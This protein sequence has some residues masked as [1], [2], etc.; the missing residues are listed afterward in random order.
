MDEL[1]TLSKH[2]QPSGQPRSL[3][4]LL[5]VFGPSILSVIVSSL[6]TWGAVQYV[7]GRDANRLDQVEKAAEKTLSRDEFQTWVAE[8][9]ERLREINDRLKDRE[10]LRK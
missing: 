5:K 3:V 7:K 8:Q 4:R 6:F 2:V 1:L 10:N 9:R